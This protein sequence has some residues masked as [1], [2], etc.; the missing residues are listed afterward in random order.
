MNDF[1]FTFVR[2]QTPR[3]TE[4]HAEHGRVVIRKVS[5]QKPG[6]KGTTSTG[7]IV[8]ADGEQIG[9][10][11][12]TATS[13]LKRLS[14]T[15]ERGTVLSVRTILGKNNAHDD[16]SEEALKDEVVRRVLEWVEDG[17]EVD[18]GALGLIKDAAAALRTFK[19]Q[20][21]EGVV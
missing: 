8:E 15:G 3:G 17:A 7:W 14:G 9:A 1:A 20:R 4:F 16:G 5:W 12:P 6:F 19:A 2:K 13:W 18:L 11:H 10:A 21:N